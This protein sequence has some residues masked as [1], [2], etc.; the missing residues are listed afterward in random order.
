MAT[1]RFADHLL[2]GVH[3]ARPAANTV[4]VGTLYSC[5]THQLIYQSD[6]SAWPTYA[7]LGASAGSVHLDDLA[8]VTAP[9]PSDQQTLAWDSGASAWVPKT[10][11]MQTLA[12]AKGDL[13]AASADNTVGRLPV[14]TDTQVLTADSTQTLGVKWAA[15]P[16]GGGGLVAV[17]TIWDAKGDLAV[18]TGADTASKLTVGS[19]G[20]VLT[21]DSSQTTGIK[22]ASAGTSPIT[23]L[24]DSTLGAAATTL[25]TLATIPAGY[26]ALDILAFLRGTSN[27]SLMRLNNDSASNYDWVRIT[28]NTS[29]GTATTNSAQADTSFP[30]RI[31]RS[32]YTTGI[33]S[34]LRMTIV[35]Y[36]DTT[37]R[38]SIS[39]YSGVADGAAPSQSDAWTLGGTWRGTAAISRIAIIDASNL[40]AGSRLIVYGLS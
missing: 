2:T 12:D 29:T 27:P 11:L 14:G 1:T 34:V 33:F 32:V 39:G 37:N 36:D 4:P 25:D 6:G 8:D 18:G 16:G 20:Q 31:A 3:S 24:F 35:G 19:N 9:T 15:A 7:T 23:K 38:K 40:F 5:T 17:D 13:F 22:W 30:I 10:A 28:T 26:T 21:A